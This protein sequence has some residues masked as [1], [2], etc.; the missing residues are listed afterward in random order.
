M[1]RGTYTAWTISTSPPEAILPL[2]VVGCLGLL[3]IPRVHLGFKASAS[4]FDSRT[5]SNY[6]AFDLSSLNHLCPSICSRTF[7]EFEI[8]SDAFAEEFVTARDR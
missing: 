7:D 6:F 1:H 3:Q 5:R 2:R 4:S 8:L